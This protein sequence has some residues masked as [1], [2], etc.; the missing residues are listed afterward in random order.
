MVNFT[1]KIIIENFKSIRSLELDDCRRINLLIGRPNVG[2]SNI[3]EAFA[4]FNLHNA[5]HVKDKS[6]RQFIR[7][8]S[9][10]QLFFNGDTNNDIKVTVGTD[11]YRL[12]ENKESSLNVLTG[13]LNEEAVVSIN[14]LSLRSSGYH[15]PE[16]AIIKSY[17]F[18][19]PFLFEDTPLK[20]LHPTTGCNL[21][22]VLKPLSEVVSEISDVLSDYGLKLSFDSSSSQLRF[23]KELPSGEVFTV[24]FNSI[25]DTLQRM[26]FYKTAVASN[27]NSII[28]FEE[29]E[30]NSYPPYISKI[31]ADILYSTSNQFFITT[32]SPYVVNDFLEDKDCS[33]A[34]YLVNYQNGE[35][36]VKRLS[37]GEL[38]Q[39]YEYGIDLFFNN[40]IFD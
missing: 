9:E 18:N 17:F 1:D 5:R 31:T 38:T 26:I 16:E 6:I 22:R 20:Y 32:H 36:V 25:A 19:S 35:T 29:P 33:L 11:I 21:Y 8:E 37:D 4:L 13:Y 12:S 39:V 30:A 15:Q 3:L 2:K 23:W 24:P 10:A 34:I 40:E 28:T 7:T 14:K 27:T